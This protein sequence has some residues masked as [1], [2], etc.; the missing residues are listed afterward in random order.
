MSDYNPADIPATL[1]F[2]KEVLLLQEEYRTALKDGKYKNSDDYFSDDVL[3]FREDKVKAIYL[4]KVK[5]LFDTIR[6]NHNLNSSLNKTIKVRFNELYI[7]AT[8]LFV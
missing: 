3:I 6:I 1:E 2:Q 8:F 7:N 5:E 4:L